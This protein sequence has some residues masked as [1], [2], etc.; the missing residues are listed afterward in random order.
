MVVHP[1]VFRLFRS[2]Q[3]H[4]WIGKHF[5][6]SS[7]VLR[8]PLW[9]IPLEAAISGRKACKFK[10]IG[11]QSSNWGNLLDEIGPSFESCFH[12]HTRK[13]AGTIRLIFL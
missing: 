11:C 2:L 9:L 10:E 13:A 12:G 7:A 5:R 8:I 4:P 6:A 3:A 1:I